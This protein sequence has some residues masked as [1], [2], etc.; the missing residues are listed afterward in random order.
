MRFT[1]AGL[2]RR[3]RL[4]IL[5]TAVLAAGSGTAIFTATAANAATG[6]SVS[7]TVTNQWPGGFGA[8]VNITNLGD[9]ITSWTLKWAFANGQTVTQLWNGSVSQ[10]G[11]NVTVTNLSYN[12]SI[13]T[14]ATLS[15]MGFNGSWTG[16]NSVPTAFTLNGTNCTGGVST[17]PT[18]SSPT[19][20]RTTASPTPS[21]TTAS[22]TPSR[23]TTSPTPSSTQ[24]NCTNCPHVD[25]PYN[26]AK[27]YVNPDWAAK[28]N[29]E[30]G[31]SRISN[32]PTGVWLDSMAAITAPAG[33]GYTT[34]LSG[35]L[36]NAL[37]QGATAAQFVIYDLPGR[38]CA[39]LASNGE[40]PPDGLDTYE[41]SYIDPIASI[42][43]NSKYSGIRIILIIEIDSLPNLVTNV[44]GNTATSECATMQQ[45]GGYVKGVQYA[46]NQFHAIPNV[47]NYVDAAHSGWLG[48]DSNFG[49][50][51]SLFASTVQGTTAGFASV[52]GFISDTANYTPTT[53]PFINPT[54]TVGSGQEMSSNFYQFN[55]YAAELPYAQ[56][57]YTKAVAAGF[58]S[59][60]GM[61]IDTSRNGWGGAN[62]PTAAS[63]STDLNTFVDQSRI[64]KRPSRGDWCN[65]SGAGLG[66]RPQANP[67]THVD[68]F[69][70]IKPP[71][72]SDGSSSLIPT[73]PN[74][75]GGKGFD[76]MCDPNYGGNARNN[77][78]A[79][80][81]LPNSPVSGAWFSA[82]F[83]QLMQNAFPAL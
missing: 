22:P 51:I 28:A 72:E 54:Q 55:P 40:I 81:A 36:D 14:G 17:G 23:T 49:P 5:L 43:S 39:A 80:G 64:D 21:R 10:S 58:P 1:A 26:G 78:S 6:C 35:H 63:T 8:A 15:G 44:S 82:Q 71:G 38:D 25:N 9:P 70:W 20:T 83:Q 18:T 24:T 76:Q 13:G 56:A 52:D 66:A 62:R 2:S 7:Y 69:V 75:P 4:G 45:N 11:A 30:S 47:Y 12:G 65:Q 79:T 61:L 57:F 59:S 68:A 19:P 3:A 48:W 46:L 37:A 31:G 74:N 32:Q 77:N 34:S 41:H 27:M 50:A 53:E 16:T 42:L 67:A 29:A 73:G 60:I 33:S